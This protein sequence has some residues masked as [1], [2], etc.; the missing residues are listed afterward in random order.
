MG[1]AA[2]SL[3]ACGGSSTAPETVSTSSA[4]KQ[5]KRGGTLLRQS[6][7]ETQGY[8]FDPQTET[9]LKGQI[10]RIMYQGLIGPNPETYDLEPELAQ[11]WEQPSQTE[12]LLRLNPGVKFHNKPPANGREMTIDDV[13]FSLNR[14]RTNNPTFTSGSL[15]S[16][17]D[18]MEAADR[19]TL[20][21][22]R[23]RMRRSSQN[24]Q[25]TSS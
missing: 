13:I 21:L 1:L 5:P 23:N 22:R 15:L 10:Y 8:N 12:Y 16:T 2:S 11:K 19:Q 9:P 7:L 14:A 24:F 17:I 4:A 6:G 18:K 20:S 25:V 3:I